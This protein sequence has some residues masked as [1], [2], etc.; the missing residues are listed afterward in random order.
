MSTQVLREQVGVF[1]LENLTN[2]AIVTPTAGYTL[3]WNGVAWVA[4][5]QTTVSGGGGINFYLDDTAIIATGAENSIE[6]NTLSKTPITTAEVVDGASITN[7]TALYEAYLYNAALNRTSFP[8]GPW[9]L[10]TYARINSLSGVG[11]AEVIT[12]I[13]RVIPSGTC[14]ITGTGT[15]RTLSV[16]GGVSVFSG[17]DIGGGDITLCSYV[18][19]PKGLYRVT[20]VPDYSIVDISVP[21]GYI[22]ETTVAFSVWRLAFNLTTGNITTT[23]LTFYPVPYAQAAITTVAADKIGA[24]YFL[25]ST[26]S[27]AKTVSFS[28]NGT[29]HYSY[30][31]STLATL[32]NNIAGVNPVGS[33]E[34]YGHV[35]FGTETI[36]GAKTFDSALATS[37][38]F[39]AATNIISTAGYLSIGTPT[40]NTIGSWK[41]SKTGTVLA[42]TFEL[43]HYEDVSGD[44]SAYGYVNKFTIDYNGAASI[45]SVPGS[46]LYG[47][48]TAGVIT[49]QVTSVTYAMQINSVLGLAVFGINQNN[50]SKA[51]TGFNLQR[52]GVEK[53]FVGM[54]ATTDNLIFRL[55]ASSNVMSVDATGA[56][57]VT[58]GFLS[59]WISI[60]AAG[61][62]Y[63][64]DPYTA[65]S[66]RFIQSGNNLIIQR[67]DAGTWTTKDTILA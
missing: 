35:G 43:A 10:G 24:L 8:A 53:W 17:S 20:A 63:I 51:Y 52:Q 48:L 26:Y 67:N 30:F 13:R 44:G 40:V 3:A 56:L 49:A 33:A 21:S 41:Q 55:T 60:N 46:S 12:G 59:P 27:G 66:W 47:A 57:T 45:W 61:G 23:V 19:T 9:V 37:G 62:I 16:T 58:G 32:H 54:D 4:A 15:T 42:T 1:N 14:S 36:Y 50:A 64:G 38:A 5:P 2:T 65:G 11:T 7:T 6:V 29:T 34:T 18:Q 39:T 28:H 31:Q 25:K 22:N